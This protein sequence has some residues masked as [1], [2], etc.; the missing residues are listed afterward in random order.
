[1]MS[2]NVTFNGNS[3]VLPT[4]SE[5]GWGTNVTNYLVALASGA[6][7]PSNFTQGIRTDANVS[8]SVLTSDNIVRLSEASSEL[9]VTLP[10]GTDGRIITL[11]DEGTSRRNI[12]ITGVDTVDSHKNIIVL[13]YDTSAW[14]V[15]ENIPA[16]I[17]QDAIEIAEALATPSLPA[18]DSFITSDD[19]GVIS[20]TGK[21]QYDDVITTV[22]NFLSTSLSDAHAIVQRDAS[23]VIVT[24][25]QDDA[26]LLPS[27]NDAARPTP[28]TGMFRYNSTS[29][30]L[31]FYDGSAWVKSYS[32]PQFDTASGEAYELVSRDASGAI[33]SV[34][35]TDAVKFPVGTTAQRPTPETGMHRYNSDTGKVEYY[36]S[37]EWKVLG[38]QD[39][40]GSSLGDLNDV[41]VPTPSDGQLLKY[42]DASGKWIAGSGFPEVD[43]DNGVY[44]RKFGEWVLIVG[45][46]TPSI[47][48][49]TDSTTINDVSPVIT[50]STFT[51]SGV[52][53]ET[54][55]KSY[56]QIATD[57]AFTSLL[58]DDEWDTGDL[59]EY[60]VTGTSLPEETE[61]YIRIK[62]EST[63]GKVSE[64]SNTV[65]VNTGL[66]V[67]LSSPS[68]EA[69][70][71]V[72]EG[73]NLTLELVNTFVETH[74]STDWELATDESF[75]SIVFS[76][77]DDTTNKTSI[78]VDVDTYLSVDT[79]YWRA[80]VNYGSPAS[81]SEWSP[82]YEFTITGVNP[83]AGTTYL[84]T[85]GTSWTAAGATAYNIKVELWGGGG[86][87]GDGNTYSTG[88]NGGTTSMFSFSATGGTGGTGTSNSNAPGGFGS[89]GNVNYTGGRGGAS[90]TG[91][92]DGIGGGGGGAASDYGNGGAGGNA[93][94]NGSAG[95]SG[96][97]AG[98]KTTTPDG[99][100][101][102]GGAGYN[103]GSS[104]GYFGGTG[105]GT[106]R[107]GGS[108]GETLSSYEGGDGGTG[109]G[110]GGG[111]GYINS[112][113]GAGG[114]YSRKNSVSVTGGTSYT[115]SIGSGGN[116]G[117]AGGNGGRG[118]IIITV[119]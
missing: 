24:T 83:A 19:A 21:A 114:G 26:I 111:R 69:S 118:Q 65:Q 75:T 40:S 29:N 60:T 37:T 100:A 92:D 51:S 108:A 35:S 52:I 115:Y 68:D 79:F 73:E 22:D 7:T 48:S 112:S 117:G 61:V 6:L 50:G 82:T 107:S 56:I 33:R 10:T 91:S 25:Q 88:F 85:S 90:S 1:M 71:G 30:K 16:N 110:G 14:I 66:G 3:Y 4:N 86:G 38:S 36:N 15:L 18:A 27:G 44:G 81:D 39:E 54:H 103:G 47:T 89:G 57:D 41:N 49:P 96:G 116:G 32:D 59:T 77:Y 64:W 105:S 102:G 113:G 17:S 9:T 101:G 70:V 94:S 98:G 12:V 53:S 67:Q 106:D 58:V 43:D 28:E 63:E 87:G 104:A 119:L 2:V 55:D 31:E 46:Q 20:Y 109:G 62:Y 93:G 80:R 8:V 72:T 23:G 11:I 13:A 78:D 42:D 34:A 76:S 5:R 95:A 45:I 74:N 97:G 99:A 84:L